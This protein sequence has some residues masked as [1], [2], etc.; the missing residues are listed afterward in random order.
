MHSES[1]PRLAGR[2]V[3]AGEDGARHVTLHRLP[4]CGRPI[5]GHLFFP[6]PRVYATSALLES[7]KLCLPI[8]QLGQLKEHLVL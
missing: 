7:I 4:R 3:S 1:A 2:R 8:D 6:F 5:F